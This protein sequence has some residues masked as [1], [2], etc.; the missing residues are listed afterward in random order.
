MLQLVPDADALMNPT[1]RLEDE[2]TSVLNKILQAS[3]QE[4]VVH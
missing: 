2:Q 4:E 3:H 1:K